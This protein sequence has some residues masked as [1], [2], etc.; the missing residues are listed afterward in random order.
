VSEVRTDAFALPLPEGWADRT[1]VT[2]AGPADAGGYAPNI[3]VTREAL[4]DHMGLGG[5]SQGWQAL[6]ADQVPVTPLAPVEHTEIAGRPANVRI[7]SW[8]AAGVRLTQIAFLFVDHEIGY[9][10]VGTC[11]EDRFEELEPVFRSVAAGF[12]LAQEALR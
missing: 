6:L 12:Q 10:V 2:L 5:F 1:V 11:T 8:A 9:A 3:V 4:C 7:V